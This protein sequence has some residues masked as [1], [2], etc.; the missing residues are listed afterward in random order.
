M[1][2]CEEHLCSPVEH[3]YNLYTSKDIKKI[4]KFKNAYHNDNA[5]SDF[6]VTIKSTIH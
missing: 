4:I 2:I 3:L 1:I 6:I 5:I